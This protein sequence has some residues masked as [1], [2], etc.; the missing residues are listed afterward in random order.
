MRDAQEGEDEDDAK[1]GP[2]EVPDGDDSGVPV[3]TIGIWTQDFR[4]SG[5]QKSLQLFFFLI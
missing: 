2:D 4:E 1:D 3:K 5:A